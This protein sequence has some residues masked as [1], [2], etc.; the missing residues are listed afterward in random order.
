[1]T[2]SHTIMALLAAGASLCALVPPRPCQAQSLHGSNASINRM[3]HHARAER[4]SFYETPRGIRRAVAAGRLVRLE[5]DANFDLHRVSYPYVRPDTRTFVERLG[6]QYRAACGEKLEVTSAVRPATRQPANSVA[7][8]VHPT[9]MAVDLH[10]SE[11]P[12]CLR[13]MRTTLR[14]LEDEGVLEA[15]EEFAP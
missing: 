5:P 13:W 1:M 4:L 8:S 3:Y 6:Q 15:T 7:R 2:T 14:A 12:K 11:N 10:K 9:G